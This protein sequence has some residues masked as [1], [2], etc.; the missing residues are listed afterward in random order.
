MSVKLIVGLVLFMIVFVGGS[1]F[2]LAGG[3]KPQI[4]TVSYS[5]SDKEKPVVEVN[6]TFFDYGKIKVSEEKS[7]EFTI[8]NIGKKPLQISNISS[9]CGCTVGQIIYQGKVSEEFSMHNKS[10]FVVSVA[11]NTEAKVKVT[12]RPY[13]MPVY[14]VV[15]RE[16][17]V[18]TNDPINQKIV[19]KVRSFVQ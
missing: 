10:D 2:L 6:E 16:V 13:V 1:Y 5:S 11:S 7:K 15:E 12:Y 19:F 8:K 3:N 18:T 9:S 4:P 14:G 17:Y